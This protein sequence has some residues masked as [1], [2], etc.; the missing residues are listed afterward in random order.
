VVVVASLTLIGCYKST[1]EAPVETPSAAYGDQQHRLGA[2][3]EARQDS[4]P[5]P[6]PA[7]PETPVAIAPVYIPVNEIESLVCAYFQ[8]HCIAALT[9]MWCESGGKPASIGRGDNYGLFQ[10]NII[11]ARKWPEFWASWMI[12]EWNVAKAYSIWL[13]QG[14]KPWG[15]KP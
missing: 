9:V 14:W 7:V 11:H 5:V 12:P 4:T 8:D 13:R 10:I 15:C 2:L 3:K 1:I 6:S